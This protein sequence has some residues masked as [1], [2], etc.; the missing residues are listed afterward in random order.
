MVITITITGDTKEII[1]EAEVGVEVEAGE[2]FTE[3]KKTVLVR[4]FNFKSK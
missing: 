3:I 1:I 2:I 4:R